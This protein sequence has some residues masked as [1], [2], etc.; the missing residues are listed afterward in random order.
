[1][2]RRVVPAATCMTC[3]IGTRRSLVTC[4]STVWTTYVAAGRALGVYLLYLTGVLPSEIR[5]CGAH[6]QVE[7]GIHCCM[8]VR[9]VLRDLPCSF[10]LLSLF[11]N[12][13]DTLGCVQ[14]L[15]STQRTSILAV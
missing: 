6:R 4:I 14:R 12:S 7:E 2:L 15:Q 10:V 8:P 9:V 5:G 11:P 13:P 1:M 3:S